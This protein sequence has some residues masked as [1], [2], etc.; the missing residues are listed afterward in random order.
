MLSITVSLIVSLPKL[1]SCISLSLQILWDIEFEENL[2]NV[3]NCLLE[4]MLF[5]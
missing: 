4:M 2:A 3:T 1:V 5:V